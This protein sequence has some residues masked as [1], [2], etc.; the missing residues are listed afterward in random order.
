MLTL[1]F[2]NT[3]GETLSETQEAQNAQKDTLNNCVCQV[4]TVEPWRLCDLLVALLF[5][6]RSLSK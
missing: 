6:S 5:S 4:G 2:L 3:F 1:K